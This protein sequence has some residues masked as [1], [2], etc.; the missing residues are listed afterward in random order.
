MLEA[1][2]S[3]F[4]AP[5]GV[6]EEQIGEDSEEEKIWQLVKE[7]EQREERSQSLQEA[8]QRERRELEKLNQQ[9]V[10]I[11][12]IAE[13]SMLVSAWHTFNKHLAFR[14]VTPSCVPKS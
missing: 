12:S 10:I 6:D 2:C 7:Q 1:T 14:E 11:L 4:S 3:L 8:L 5:S 9:R 13:F